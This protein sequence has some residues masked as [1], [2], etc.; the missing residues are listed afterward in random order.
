MYYY[1]CRGLFYFY[2]FWAAC[3]MMAAQAETPPEQ[4][5]NPLPLLQSSSFSLP[6][7]HQGQ[8]VM[9]WEELKKILEELE[10]LKQQ[11]HDTL[12][13]PVLAE[14][15]TAYTIQ[16]AELTGTLQGQAARF[17]VTLIVQSLTNDW[18]IIPLF[19]ADTG[20]EALTITAAT[21][22]PAKTTG[23]TTPETPQPP[24]TYTHSFLH[25]KQ[26]YALLTQGAQ[27]LTL[28]A[29]IHLPVQQEELTYQL[30]LTPPRAVINRLQLHIPEKGVQLLKTPPYSQITSSETGTTLAVVPHESVHFSWRIEKNSTA[31]RKS[32][33]ALQTLISVTPT[34]L[35]MTSHI[36]LEQV[37]DLNQ[38]SL[39]LPLS[40]EIMTLTS[41]DI[42][43]WFTQ[44]ETAFQQIKIAG[45]ARNPITLDLS[46]RLKLAALGDI[47]V[48]MPSLEGVEAREEWAGVEVLGN[49]EATTPANTAMVPPKNLPKAL[50]QRASSPLLYG[51]SFNQADFSPQ[52]SLRGLQEI[53]TVIANA[54]QADGV[55]LR[56]LEGRSMT[57]V[58]YAIRNNDR[59]F[60]TVTLPQHSHIWQAFL[61]D[62]PVK[63]AQ[64][65]SGEILIPM[66]KSAAQGE[67]LQSFR[68]ELGYITDVD[69]LSLKGTLLNQLP[70]VDIPISYLRWRLYLP[71][72]Y[73]YS[74][75]EGPLKQVQGGWPTT[76]IE[77]KS[78]IEIPLQGQVF[79][80]EKHLVMAEMPYVRGQ[81]GQFLGDDILL[82][83]PT[84]AATT[85]YPLSSPP[86]Y[87]HATE[88]YNRAPAPSEP[89]LRQQVIP[90][91]AR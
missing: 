89:E 54:D 28:N 38:I 6:A 65:D 10:T 56:T 2:V 41:P 78:L 87:D 1:L 40:V 81:Y 27:T 50:W 13:K 15:P 76:T 17:A 7:M 18:T 30:T 60:L 4:Q 8:V 39:K 79:Y 32:T 21:P 37:A 88:N 80:F 68:L 58:R 19:S 42:E 85:T 82:T 55:T 11:R 71:E 83:V 67:A 61:D 69:K 74:A 20:V 5:P 51:W 14:P 3:I 53:Q 52:L 23:M 12:K 66:K 34:E 75:F 24:P 22:T 45:Q 36:L 59:Q 43:Q 44:K 73:E 70:A 64:K 62:K 35:L 90:N 91:R 86:K 31:N 72:Y 84:P 16:Q 57:R 9:R 47:R 77:P 49:L 48:P 25:D 26:G 63:P 46:Y 33:A 29:V